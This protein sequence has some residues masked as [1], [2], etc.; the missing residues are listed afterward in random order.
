MSTPTASRRIELSLT[1]V[2]ESLRFRAANVPAGTTKGDGDARLVRG[3]TRVNDVEELANVVIRPD[4][5]GGSVRVGDVADV[6][7]TFAAGKF[8]GRVNGE[9]A[10]V[11]TVRKEEQA[12]SVRISEDMHALVDRLRPTLP[13]GVTI[14]LFGDAAAEVQ[15]SLGHALHERGCGALAGR[16]SPLGRHRRAERHDGRSWASR[17]PWPAQSSRCT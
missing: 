6:K 8:S 15:H 14:D 11:L 5:Q 1:T 13:P 9:P 16:T 7:D 2:T 3:M 10:I 4:A 17:S 12:D